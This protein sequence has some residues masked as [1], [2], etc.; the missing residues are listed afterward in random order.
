ME[1]HSGSL[2]RSWRYGNGVWPSVGMGILS[3]GV[4]I[5]TCRLL[6]IERQLSVRGTLYIHS[7]VGS[8]VVLAVLW[9]PWLAGVL[10]TG[11]RGL[12]SI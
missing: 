5:R 4:T 9:Y 12:P 11:G 6:C 2:V 3:V 7:V 8:A 1:I 10:A